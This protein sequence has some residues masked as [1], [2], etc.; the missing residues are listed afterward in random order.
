MIDDIND[1]NKWS[2]ADDYNKQST[3]QSSMNNWLV[4]SNQ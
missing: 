4:V 3:E 2:M 1:D